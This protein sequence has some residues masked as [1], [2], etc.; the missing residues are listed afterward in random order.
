MA[1]IAEAISQGEQCSHCGTLFEEG[2]GHPVLCRDC[3]RN[4][5]DFERAGLPRAITKE[6]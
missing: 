4:E 6:L 1:E 3:F 2:H 5:T